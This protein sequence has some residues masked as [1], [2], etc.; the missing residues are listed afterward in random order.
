MS[1]SERAEKLRKRRQRATMRAEPIQ[2]LEHPEPLCPGSNLL[3]CGGS[4]KSLAVWRS[5][6]STSQEVR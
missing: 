2:W 3:I 5:S 1:V 4:A 6:S